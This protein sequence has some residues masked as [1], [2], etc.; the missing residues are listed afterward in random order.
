MTSST[1]RYSI[2][3]SEPI[4]FALFAVMAV[5]LLVVFIAGAAFL[6][7]NGQPFGNAASMVADVCAW[8]F[9]VA[10]LTAF[11]LAVFEQRRDAALHPDSPRH[12]AKPASH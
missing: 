12:A 1:H 6:I 10:F 9:T 4:N 8:V 3:Y 7:W 2:P 11:L 5:C